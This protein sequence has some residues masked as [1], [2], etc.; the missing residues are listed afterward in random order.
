MRE[1]IRI[2]DH[3]GDNT[4]KSVTLRNYFLNYCVQYSKISPQAYVNHKLQVQLS[5]LM[6]SD[7]TLE[8]C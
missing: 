3:S 6:M 1:F 8:I 5:F 4:W 2:P 7:I